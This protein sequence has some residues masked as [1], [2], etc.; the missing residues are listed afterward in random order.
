MIILEISKFSCVSQLSW[1]FPGI[2][3]NSHVLCIPRSQLS[4]VSL[5][6]L[7]PNVLSIPWDHWE[8]PC[9]PMHTQVP[10]L[11]TVPSISWVLGPKCPEY[12][13]GSQGIP[14]LSYAYPGPNCPEYLLGPWSQLFWSLPGITGNSHVVLCIYPDSNCVCPWKLTSSVRYEWSMKHTQLSTAQGSG[15]L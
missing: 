1:K 14:M 2:T 3:G 13:L 10:R 8:F 5:G 11:P 15:V 4:P 7:V 9:C 6:S 12:S